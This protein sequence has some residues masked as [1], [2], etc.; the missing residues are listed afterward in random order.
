VYS[1]CVLILFRL[2][3]R[4]NQL[5]RKHT[6]YQSGSEEE[7]A[8]AEEE[9]AEWVAPAE[10]WVA[11]AEKEVAPAEKEGDEDTEEL[12]EA[13]RNETDD[14]EEDAPAEVQWRAEYGSGVVPAELQWLF[15]QSETEKEQYRDRLAR[16]KSAK[17]GYLFKGADGTLTWKGGDT[18]LHKDGV[19]IG[20]ALDDKF[21]RAYEVA[22]TEIEKMERVART[23]IEK[24][25]R[26]CFKDAVRETLRDFNAPDSPPTRSLF[27]LPLLPNVL[28]LGL[29]GSGVVPAKVKQEPKPE[30]GGDRH[31]KRAKVQQEPKPEPAGDRGSKRVKVKQVPKPEPAGDRDRRGKRAKSETYSKPSW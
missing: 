16:R 23:E 26:F 1:F 6:G 13:L 12:L 4:T 10:E 8:P 31:G 21:D 2:M 28:G 7:D 22:R 27:H 11:P 9:A 30:P 18:L 14:E 25:E 29:L 19:T 20:D 3:A 24:T 5:A 17:S 15:H